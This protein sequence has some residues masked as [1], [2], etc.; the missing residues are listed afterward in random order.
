MERAAPRPPPA[1]GGTAAAT[2]RRGQAWPPHPSAPPCAG[3]RGSTP[4]HSPAG[5]ARC[6][7]LNRPAGLKTSAQPRRARPLLS[8]AS[9]PCATRRGLTRPPSL[10]GHA[11]C[12]PCARHH[13]QD[14]TPLHSPQ[15]LSQPKQG[16]AAGQALATTP[17]PLVKRDRGSAPST[18]GT[19]GGIRASALCNC[20]P[21]RL[22]AGGSGRAGVIRW[23]GGG[24]SCRTC[25]APHGQPGKCSRTRSGQPACTCA[26]GTRGVPPAPPTPHC[27]DPQPRPV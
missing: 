22:S 24:G 7:T 12:P 16:A 20:C 19:T 11:R 6:P 4:P 26:P 9:P 17:S 13:L 25:A 15:S 23:R 3:Q 8:P 5:H 1:V 14:S 18:G 2:P 21:P 10:G 27:S